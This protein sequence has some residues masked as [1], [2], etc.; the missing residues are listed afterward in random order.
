MSNKSIGEENT[1]PPDSGGGKGYDLTAGDVLG[2]YVILN[3]LGRGGMGQVY[4]A[5]NRVNGRKVALKLL[6]ADATGAGFVERFRI[7][8]RVMSDLDHPGIV[9]VH[10]AGSDKGRYY[11]TMDYVAGPEGE[12]LTLADVLEREGRGQRVEGRKE[13]ERRTSNVEHRT[14]NEAQIREIALQICDALAYA[15]RKGI[16]H[17]DLKPANI[18]VETGAPIS[19]SAGYKGSSLTST[20]YPLTSPKIRITDFGLAKVVG[21]EFVSAMV[22]KSISLSM[23]RSIGEG[24]TEPGSSKRAAYE[25]TSTGALLGTYDYM[26][27]EQ[28]AGGEVTKQSDI[29]AFGVILYRMLTGRKPEGMAKPPS[30]FGCAPGWDAVVDKCL[31]HDFQDR[32]GDVGELKAVLEGLGK[33]RQGAGSRGRG[34]GKKN[35]TTDGRGWTR[36]G[37]G[38]VAGV[39]VLLAVWWGMGRDESPSGPVGPSGPQIEATPLATVAPV[40]EVPTPL[41]VS[42][43]EGVEL[44]EQVFEVEPAGTRMAVFGSRGL[45]VQTNVTGRVALRLEPGSY[46]VKLQKD[47]YELLKQA[48]RVEEGGRMRHFELVPLRGDMRI[49]ST[50]GAEVVAVREGND[51]PVAL[52]RVGEDGVLRYDRLVEGAYT[53]RLSHPDYQE[54]S[55][56]VEIRK[57]RAVDLEAPLTGKPG[58]VWINTSPRAEIWLGTRRLGET[59]TRIEGIP[60]GTHTLEIRQSGFRRERVE[61]VMPPNGFVRQ[62]LPNLS[63]ESGAVRVV[64]EVPDYAREFF[65]GSEVEV[66][67]GSEVRNARG[68]A[69]WTL[70]GLP[71]GAVQVGVQ[72]SG[73][74]VQGSGSVNVRDGETALARFTLE[75]LPA[76][77]SLSGAPAGA[78]VRLADGTSVSDLSDI[79]VPS[80]RAGTLRVSAPGHQDTEVAVP[81]LRPGERR[82]LAVTM[83]VL[84]GPRPEQ[85]WEVPGLGM[86]LNWVGSGSFRM[87]TA[88]GG[89][90]NERP[91]REVRISRG[92]WMG[93]YEV[94]QREYEALM[95]NNPS[96]FKGDG[97]RPVES[98]SWDDAVAFCRRLT[99][100]ERAAG[101]L[102]EGYVY[103]LPTEAEW[104]YAARGGHRAR[105]TTYAGSNNVD[106]VAWHSGNAGG[107][108]RPVGGRAA[109]ELGLHDMSGN[110]WEW[111]H[112]WYQ[113]SYQGLGTLDPTGPANGSRRVR[114]GGGWFDGA[115]LCRVAYRFHWNPALRY[116]LLGFRV[117]LAPQFR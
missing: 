10:H 59:G 67:V 48:L 70:E 8:S 89:H 74:R 39:L 72:S 111:V 102:P 25:G 110:V 103:R 101:R 82:S 28:K 34:V 81:A 1:V 115:S 24:V 79:A 53:L 68:Q 100:R 83:E 32:Y 66:R 45:V 26:S 97:N 105:E 71:V 95:G 52:G 15:H 106:A 65:R 2:D 62:T 117:V 84:R 87:G 63:R 47:G 40:P 46:E 4:L 60:A 96:R 80:L 12:A 113:N 94:T 88:S 85:A 86:K 13:S 77:V 61:I 73:F 75:P 93:V 19:A 17:R 57:D 99:E 108:T 11:L 5:E 76:R 104:E 98:V 41:P 27:P 33:K 22:K 114:R 43:P 78:S 116:D 58:W 9:R 38:L 55:E 36:M 90:N 64:L 44:V 35:Q 31:E 18:L 3:P 92:F 42:P 23:G 30:H 16:V 51:A 6:P 109:N 112:D 49:R 14:L 54:R 91:V 107:Q 69:E 21:E 7:E 37:L 29:Y 56:R 20:L 50:A